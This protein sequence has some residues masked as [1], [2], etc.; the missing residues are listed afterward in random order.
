MV[1][2]AY[3][4]QGIKAIK[5][6]L[7]SWSVD[8]NKKIQLVKTYLLAG[9]TYQVSTWG[10]IPAIVY[11]RFHATILQA[12][13]T[14][15]H[16]KF[17]PFSSSDCLTDDVVVSQFNLIAPMTI[18]RRARLALFGRVFAKNPALLCRTI[19]V[20]STAS[21][22]KIQS[23]WMAQVL[24][25]YSIMMGP[26]VSEP[27]DFTFLHLLKDVTGDPKHF[28]QR[29]RK[30]SISLFANL[31]VPCPA[32]K[33][34]DPYVPSQPV[35]DEFRCDTCDRL[36]DT[37]QKL[38]VH[39]AVNHHIYDSLYFHLN[40]THCL[41]CMREFH[42]M[43][44]LYSHL[45][46]RSNICKANYECDDPPLSYDEVHSMFVKNRAHNRTLRLS[47]CRPTYAQNPSFRVPGPLPMP[48]ILPSRSSPHHILGF[49]RNKS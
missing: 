45:R 21:K 11:K 27:V 14:I 3:I 28:L 38:S 5:L 37:K 19:E 31:D 36:F 30:F 39:L 49:G 12:Y 42:S 13:R 44:R 32:Y 25:D 48:S 4:R 34:N 15:T 7:S 41:F 24:S 9:G 20:L 10:L 18:I 2:S 17:V 33:F 26:E 23:S 22:K 35:S 1:R 47:G 43:P 16:Q 46:Y 40:T 6:I 29:V 8:L